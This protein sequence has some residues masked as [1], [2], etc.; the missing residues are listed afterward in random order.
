MNKIDRIV[1][2]LTNNFSLHAYRDFM[3]RLVVAVSMNED[4]MPVGKWATELHGRIQ[5]MNMDVKITLLSYGTSQKEVA[6]FK[7]AVMWVKFSVY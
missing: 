2:S 1:K 3:D 5:A 6:G 7:T 4:S